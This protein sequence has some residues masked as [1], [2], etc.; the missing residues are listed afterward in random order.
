MRWFTP[1]T[2]VDLCGHAT[3]ATAHALIQSG[4]VPS[5]QNKSSDTAT[6]ISFHTLKSGILTA[7]ENDDGSITL[8]FPSQPP[9]SVVL[10]SAELTIL[11]SA[12]HLPCQESILY[13]GRNISDL[14][15]EIT[16]EA[17]ERMKDSSIDFRLLA[18]LGGRG[19]IVTKQ[20]G[21]INNRD[22]DFTS[23]CFFP[24]AG[25]DEDPVTGIR[26]L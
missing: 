2:E 16:E 19:V 13:A 10:T 8:D 22:Y 25:I 5:K 6:M 1:T 17:F 11:I 15:V 12:L 18:D 23:R 21:Q 24:C 9:N 26:C 20:G 4:H 14:L 7:V 3:L